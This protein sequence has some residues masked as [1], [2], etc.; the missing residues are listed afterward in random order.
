MPSIRPIRSV[1]PA[2]KS[3]SDASATSSSDTTIPNGMSRRILPAVSGRGRMRA[4]TPR[5]T[6]T[7]KML[8]PTTLPIATSLFPATAESTDTTSSGVEVPTATIV[9]P[10][11]NSGTRS[12]LAS[13][14]EPSV[15]KLAPAR[16]RPRPA[17][18]RRISIEGY[19]FPVRDR[20]TA[21]AP[22]QDNRIRLA[23]MTAIPVTTP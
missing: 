3:E 23:A 21:A 7:L 4:Q 12:R 13:A 8:D 18:R 11:M 6:N 1:A 5:M 17:S 2:L 22:D 16:I 9:S 10:M 15:R 14:A 19:V 20:R